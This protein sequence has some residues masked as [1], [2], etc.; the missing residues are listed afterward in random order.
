MSLCKISH[1][2]QIIAFDFHKDYIV[3]LDLDHKLHC[4]KYIFPNKFETIEIDDKI[5]EVEL[6]RNLQITVV[7]DKLSL[8]YVYNDDC[9]K[10]V[11]KNYDIEEKT[12]VYQDQ[13]NIEM[14]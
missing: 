12:L 14:E 3:Y 10:I 8:F 9:E 2:Q 11:V 6:L 1:N 7:D 4:Q 5:E 13:V